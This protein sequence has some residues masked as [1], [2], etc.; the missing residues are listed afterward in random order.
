M[1]SLDPARRLQATR[2]RRQGAGAPGGRR[3]TGLATCSEVLIGHRCRSRA[4]QA[5]WRRAFKHL[6]LAKSD[7]GDSGLRLQPAARHRIGILSYSQL[8]NQCF[9]ASI[10]TV[11][12]TCPQPPAAGPPLSSQQRHPKSQPHSPLA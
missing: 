12:K 9:S 4:F 1:Q 11:P 10:T 7:E 3:P 5:P 8:I 2:C 6:R